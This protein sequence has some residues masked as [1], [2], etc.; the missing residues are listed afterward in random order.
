[1][2]RKQFL[3]ALACSTLAWAA[4]PAAMA[5]EKPLEWVIGYA[6][7]GGSD[8]VARVIAESMGRNLERPIV[9]NNKPGAGTNIA[10][11]YS[12]RS[13]DYGNLM[14]TADFATLAANPFLFRK[15]NY[16]AE[17]DFKP[18]GMLVRFP[19][20]LVVNNDVPVS[21]LT[22]FVAWAKQQKAGV[23]WGSAGL[24]SPHHLVGE[25]FREEVGLGNMTHVPYRGAAPAVQDV[26]GG[27]IPAMWADS[28]TIVPFLG[29]KKLKAIGVA[30]PARI[31][32]LP[33]VATLQEQGLK[34][35]EGYAWQGIV[36]PKG[37]SAEV[38]K[39]FSQSLQF[40][41]ADTRTKARLA[42]MG[43]EPMPGSSEQ[44]EKFVST[45]RSKWGRVITANNIKLD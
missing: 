7:G 36:V 31:D 40:A 21:N 2:Q 9:I 10:A 35:F 30:S 8:V 6:A 28:A 15:L 13:H 1:M 4:G 29:E 41:L 44:M 20:L 18:V 45:E 26:I 43:V 27:Q 24:G 3:A 11:E 16:N 38:V 19:M 17:K 23:S 34:G 39:K 33:K 12:A 14:F 25:L 22:E 42:A 37:S 5:Q 32:V